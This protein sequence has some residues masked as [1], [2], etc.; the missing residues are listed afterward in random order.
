MLRFQSL[1]SSVSQKVPEIEPSRFPNGGPLLTELSIS[2]AFFYM[3]LKFHIKIL[4]IKKK[5]PPSLEGPKKGTPSCSPK[6]GP[7]GNRHPFPGP[8]LAYPS[9]SPV[10]EPSLQV[11]LIRLP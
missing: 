11:S 4:L 6:W 7:Y 3:S 5:F 8:Y 1:P 9:G 2:K 10:K